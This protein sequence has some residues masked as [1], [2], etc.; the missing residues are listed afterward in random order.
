MA[1]AA[2]R[3]AAEFLQRQAIVTLPGSGAGGRGAV[4]GVL[5]LGV[6]QHVDAR[7]VRDQAEPRLLLPDRRRCAAGRPIGRKS[8]CATSIC[9]RSGTSRFTRCIPATSSTPSTLRQVES[10][11]RKSHVLRARRRSSKGWAH[12]CEQ[13][14]M[15]A[16][17]RKG[18]TRLQAWPAGRGAGAAGARSSS[19]SAC[20]ART[21]RWSRGC[22]SSG[23][24]RFSRRPRRAAKPSAARSIP[25]YVVYSIGKLMMLKLRQRLQGTAGGPSSRC[26]RSTTP[27][28]A[29]AAR[30]SGRIATCCSATRRPTPLE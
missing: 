13:M 4:A 5:P 17:F 27:C 30:R 20:T 22:A 3:G 19:A 2:A 6:C 7:A 8:T 23:T 10:K 1:Q 14:M 16:G 18:D 26:A 24:R 11:V 29:R 15:E 12:Y 9:R 25:S 21:C 28:S